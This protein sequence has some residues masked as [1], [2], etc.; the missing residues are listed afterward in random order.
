MEGRRE[1]YDGTN[2][3]SILAHARRL[4]GRSLHELYP[5]L[6]DTFAGRG[7]LGQCV[8]EVHFGYECN[9][10]GEPDFDQAGVELKCTPMKENKDSSMTAKERLVLN[11][12][13]YVKEADKTFE[14]SS[15][16]A[17]NHDLLLMFY[18]YKQ[19]TEKLDLLFKIIRMWNIP[20]EDLKI[21][22]DDWRRI[23]EKIASGRAH[24]ISEGDTLYLAACTKGSKAGAEMRR[25]PGTEVKAQQRAYSIKAS[26]MNYVIL[27]SMGHPEMCSGVEMSEREKKKIKE[28]IKKAREKYGAAVK[29]VGEY[30]EGETFE[31]LVERRFKE[32][33]GKT[34]GEIGLELGKEISQSPKA[35]SWSVCRAILGVDAEKIAEFEKAGIQIKTIRLE[36]NGR[37][38]EAMSFRN[39]NYMEIVNEES[40]EDSAWYDMV[41]SHRFLFVVF[42]KQSDGDVMGAVLE[43]VFFWNMPQ[44]DLEKCRGFWEDTRDKVRG[45]DYGN[46]IRQ[47]QHEICHVRPKGKNSE[48]L[49]ETP[50]GGEAKK[51]C[52]WL[53]R[54]YVLGILEGAGVILSTERHSTTSSQQPMPR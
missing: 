3:E 12:I 53:N 40:W 48:D 51:Y 9:S 35:V 7:G 27:E 16:M 15:F 17:K 46:F 6:E 47:T 49:A 10:R 44:E 50:Q 26:Y 33:T 38:K 25:Q 31:G 30:G 8:E 2:R 14:T 23:H 28:K 4:L 20:E 21:F 5:W 22:I 24:E 39:I 19:G 43:R 41:G 36:K 13:D 37:L 11:V 18:L 32:F 52:Y 34:V 42:R 1:E 54:D 29:S 45:N